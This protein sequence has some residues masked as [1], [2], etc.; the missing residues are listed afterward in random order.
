MKNFNHERNLWF[1]HEPPR[2]FASNSNNKF[3]SVGVVSG[4]NLLFLCDLR[5]SA[6]LRE[7]FGIKLIFI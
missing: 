6:P 4:K 2:T 3:V 7:N 5:A 1:L